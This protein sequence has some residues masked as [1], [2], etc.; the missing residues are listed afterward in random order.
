MGSYYIGLD[1]SLAAF[2]IA[3]IDTRSQRIILDQLKSDNHHDFMLMCWAIENLWQLFMGKYQYYLFDE[4]TYIAQE[5]PIASGINSGKLNALGIRFYIGCGNESNYTKIRTYQPIKLKQF[6]RK[7]GIKKYNK[8]D[9][10]EVVEDLLVYLESVGYDIDIRLSRT[11][12]NK[13]ITD[14][15]ADAFMYAIKTYIDKR[16]NAETTKYILDKYPMFNI[17]ESLEEVKYGV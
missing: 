8:K 16:P 6:H 4:E 13:T 15:E 2:G 7:R 9:T 11:K 14:G 1:P 12:K 3:I 10:I 5:A 17:I